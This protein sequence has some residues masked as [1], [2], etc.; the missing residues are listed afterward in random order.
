[1]GIGLGWARRSHQGEGKGGCWGRGCG[2]R[3]S[4]YRVW[5]A[6]AACLDF[7][8]A[9]MAGRSALLQV[10]GE[11]VIGK[12]PILEPGKPEFVYCSCTH[13]PGTRGAME[14][15]F[16]FVPGTIERPEGPPFDVACPTFRL[17]IPEY[18][19]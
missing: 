13:Q 8:P 12:Y 6:Q 16:Q 2:P 19:F 5:V 3:C 7:P 11:G 10:R 18:I 15:E 1:M 17:D 14:G 9:E 4:S